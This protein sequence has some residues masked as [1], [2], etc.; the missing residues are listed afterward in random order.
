MY[1]HLKKEFFSLLRWKNLIIFGLQTSTPSD[2]KN[3]YISMKMHFTD[4]VS[5]KKVITLYILIRFFRNIVKEKPIPKI[6]FERKLRPTQ[7]EHLY[8]Y[9]FDNLGVIYISQFPQNCDFSHC[10]WFLRN[11]GTKFCKILSEGINILDAQNNL[12]LYSFK[13]KFRKYD[14][15][16]KK[17]RT[18]EIFFFSKNY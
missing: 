7:F 10:S 8:I 4:S 12:L 9:F 1:G 11:G 15:N 16:Y 6:A 18:F 5:Q 13:K 14:Y 17:Y 2:F 3:I